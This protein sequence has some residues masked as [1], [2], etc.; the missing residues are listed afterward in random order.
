MGSSI[1]AS[2][3]AECSCS[4]QKSYRKASPTCGQTDRHVGFKFMA[5]HSEGTLKDG[6]FDVLA[7]AVCRLDIPV[8]FMWRRN[9]LRRLISFKANVHDSRAPVLKAEQ[10]SHDV[11]GSSKKQ[12]GHEPHPVD[13]EIAALLRQYRPELNA[14]TI[15]K[16]IAQEERVRRVIERSFKKYASVCEVA[17]NA[18]T[19]YYEELMDGVPGAAEKWGD[20]LSTLRIWK[21]SD[22]AIIHGEQKVRETISNARTIRNA[23]RDSPFKWMIDE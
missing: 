8:I 14:D 21:N 6:A 10:T 19:F 22:L 17:R 1:G 18:K 15:A 20:L 5:P 9:I 7:R 3:A 4:L 23:L 16:D 12:I 11:G 2:A 13:P